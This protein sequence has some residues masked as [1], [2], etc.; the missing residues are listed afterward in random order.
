MK[1]L[2][3]GRNEIYNNITCMQFNPKNRKEKKTNTYGF[4]VE[5]AC[6]AGKCTLEYLM[7]PGQL[8]LRLLAVWNRFAF[9]AC[10]SAN[11]QQ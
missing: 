2:Q 4:T 3:Q 10:F 5:T 1:C 7:Y 8:R 11:G 9:A 6:F